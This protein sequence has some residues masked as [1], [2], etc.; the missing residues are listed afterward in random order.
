LIKK[1]F[2]ALTIPDKPRNPHQKYILTE[3]GMKHVRA[4]K[5]GSLENVLEIVRIK[6]LSASGSILYV[7]HENLLL[8]Y[9]QA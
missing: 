2:L 3:A 7:V 5:F 9:K 4:R 8:C 1:N 6:E